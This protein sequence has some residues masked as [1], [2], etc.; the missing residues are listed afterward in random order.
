[1]L[2]VADRKKI[3]SDIEFIHKEISNAKGNSQP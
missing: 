2:P 3:F 1:M